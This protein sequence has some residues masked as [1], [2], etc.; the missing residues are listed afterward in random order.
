MIDFA[1]RSSLLTGTCAGI[2]QYLGLDG[3]GGAGGK[4][5]YPNG[6]SPHT[7]GHEPVYISLTNT[8][9]PC[10]AQCVRGIRLGI[11]GIHKEFSKD[12]TMKKNVYAI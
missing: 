6:S 1:T 5:T 12:I 11:C 7:L 8:P 3:G 9:Y 4:L 2:L 10:H